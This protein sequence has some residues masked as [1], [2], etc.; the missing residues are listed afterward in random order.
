MQAQ[1]SI[2]GLREKCIYKVNTRTQS[3]GQHPVV[4]RRLHA[5]MCKYSQR[6]LVP[7]EREHTALDWAAPREKMLET[8][9]LALVKQWVQI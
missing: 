5:G 1:N 4:C 6:G 9:N 8:W 2:W 7:G 3:Q